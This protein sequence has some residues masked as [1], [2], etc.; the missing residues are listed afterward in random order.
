MPSLKCPVS[1]CDWELQDLEKDLAFALATSLQTH[2]TFSHRTPSVAV[3]AEKNDRPTIIK[4]CSSKDWGY[5]ISLWTSYKTSTKLS[6][7][8]TR[9]NCW[10]A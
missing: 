9:S 3:K 4:G 2:I 1:G 10:L 5:F 7:A 6:D 8:D